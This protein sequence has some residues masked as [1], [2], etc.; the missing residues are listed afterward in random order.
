MTDGR[1]RE[2]GE[3]RKRV[4]GKR[5]ERR[6]QNGERDREEKVLGRVKARGK[7]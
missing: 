1:D 5:E 7:K 4:E 6:S 3:S 2:K